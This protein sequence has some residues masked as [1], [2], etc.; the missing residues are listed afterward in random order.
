MKSGIVIGLYTLLALK[1]IGYQERP[2]K[3]IMVTDEENLHMFS[4]AKDKIR[5]EA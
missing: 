2:I 5:Q 4:K 3:F 1:M